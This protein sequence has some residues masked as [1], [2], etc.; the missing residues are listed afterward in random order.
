VDDR[1]PDL[2]PTL[3]ST[4][5]RILAIGI[6]L[7]PRGRGAFHG[8]QMAQALAGGPD[9]PASIGYGTLYRALDRLERLGYLASWWA[10]PLLTGQPRRRMY[11]VTPA[12]VAAAALVPSRSIARRRA[13]ARVTACT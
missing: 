9:R 3:S 10:E 5:R 1:D 12:G 8:Y 2:V 7:M 11:A 13:R 6:E 4:E